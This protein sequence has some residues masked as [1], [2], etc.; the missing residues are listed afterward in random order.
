[1]KTVLHSD[2]SHS[3]PFERARSLSYTTCEAYILDIPDPSERFLLVSLHA[4]LLVLHIAALAV[5]GQTLA[6]DPTHAVNR[7]S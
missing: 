2:V 6:K 5:A 7:P 4:D 1:M 3:L